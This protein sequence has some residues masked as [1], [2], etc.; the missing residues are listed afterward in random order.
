MPIRKN[1]SGNCQELIVSGKIDGA[2]ANEM[3]LAVLAAIKA[4]AQEVFIN[5]SEAEFICSAGIR[6]ILQY[7][8]QMRTSGKK[9]LVTRPS[10]AI[11]AILDMTGFKHSIVEGAAPPAA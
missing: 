7:F 3:E 4:G 2:T 9:L 6:V 8:R 1:I 5:L 11:E 10:A